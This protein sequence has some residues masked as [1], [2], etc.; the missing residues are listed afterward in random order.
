M[1]SQSNRLQ[2][3]RVLCALCDEPISFRSGFFFEPGDGTVVHPDCQ[4]YVLTFGAIPRD[5]M[6]SHTCGDAN[7]VNPRHLR[8][9]KK[10]QTGRA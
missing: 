7:C 9:V 1:H 5:L 10:P 8:P 4:S 2:F 6:M 3:D